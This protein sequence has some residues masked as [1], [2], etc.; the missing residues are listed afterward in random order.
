MGPLAADRSGLAV[1]WE[2]LDLVREGEELAA[3]ALDDGRKA[4]V[5]IRRVPR[6]AGKQRV[7]RK[8]MFTADEA[9]AARGVAR[10]MNGHHFVLAKTK[11]LTIANAVIRLDRH[12]RLVR[13]VTRELGVSLVAHRF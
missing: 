7:P 1:A 2:Y 3:N 8:E 10:R 11:P 12:H 9:D 13:L 6:T 5:R 4:G